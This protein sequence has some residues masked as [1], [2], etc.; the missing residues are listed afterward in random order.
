MKSVLIVDDEV[1][2]RES[3]RM[4]LKNDYEVFLAKNA[5][6]A[7]LQIKEHSPDTILLDIILPDLDGLKV[8]E[9]IKQT[10]P[11]MI[12]IMIT[13]TKTVKTAVEAMK[14]GA[15]D[16]V[17]K[18]FDIDELRL[19]INRALS[20]KSLKEENKRLREE[21]NKSLGFGNI[22]GKS[23]EMREIFKVV[24]QIAD[25]KSTVLIMGESGTGKELISRAIHYN[26]SRKSYPFITINC[27]AIPETL[28]ESELFGHEK[29]AF[30]D[31]IKTKKGLFEEADGGTLFLDEIGELSLTTQAKILR[32][33]EEREFNRVGGSKTI[34][35]DVR[36]ITATNKDLSQMIKKGGFREDLYYRINVVPI[37]LPPLRERREDIPLFL[38]H[39]IKKFNDE[40]NKNVKGVSKEALELM[41]NYE[42]PGNVRELENLIERVIALTSSEYIQPYELPFSLINISKINGLKES[43]LNGKV[44][45]LK[46]EEEFEREIIL[47]A[48]KRTNCVQSHA[49]EMLG[50]SRRILKYKMDK[51]GIT[52]DVI[53]NL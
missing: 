31:A 25:S 33:L 27:A 7:F 13:A 44:S 45:I 30:T 9:K 10:E 53:K 17:T 18:P 43:I 51:L 52:Q 14:L 24:R 39:F 40:N 50:I 36:L 32:F 15:Y 46:A 41:M 19:I 2:A 6:E 1:G 42:W 35:V 38:E 34:K 20:T 11:E 16:Y 8:L 22:I 37:L 47:D 12:V 49:A 28:I 21:I 26:S 5:E 3:I 29:G 4:I 48:L 23:K